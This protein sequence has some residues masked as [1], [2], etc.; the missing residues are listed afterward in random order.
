MLH[1]DLNEC[2]IV[3]NGVKRTVI[4]ESLTGAHMISH[5]RGIQR[6]DRPYQRLDAIEKLINSTST[7]AGRKID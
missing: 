7:Q 3:A 4:F 6:G 5:V 1:S 2:T